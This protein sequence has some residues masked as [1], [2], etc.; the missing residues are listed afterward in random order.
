VTHDRT[1]HDIVVIG[2]SAGGLEPLRQLLR[3]V[4]NDLSASIFIVMHVASP[5][6][7]PDILAR[8]SVLPVKA[9]VSGAKIERSRVYV[10]QPGTHLLLH[11]HHILL[12]RGPRENMARPAIDPLF[13]SAACSFGARVIGI[14]LSG[15]LDDG[16]A[17]LAAVKRCGGLALVQD[18]E[19][20]AVPSMPRAALAKVAVDHC[21]RIDAMAALLAR[22]VSAPVTDSPEIPLEIRLE[23][24]IAAQEKSGM[25]VE[26]RL[27]S[28]SPFSCPE[29]NGVLW[30]LSDESKT[31]YRC[32]VGHAFTSEALL[33]AKSREFEQLLSMLMRSHRERGE[34]IG[35][36]AESARA[37]QHWS[38]A[39]Y[40][41]ERANDYREDAALLSQL[42]TRESSEPD[43]D[44]PIAGEPET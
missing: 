12:R 37:A 17:G 20:A 27:G 26:D 44:A 41:E 21:V 25:D 4:P 23:A 40:F 2:A 28:T 11:D 5:S 32:H 29:C 31:R 9:A 16:T 39:S 8:S 24:A 43:D 10:A 22:L 19:D 14:I 6:L 13:R 30:E 38:S 15:A 36:M 3:E 35:R 1:I 42:L 33:A 34:I 7:L 18:P